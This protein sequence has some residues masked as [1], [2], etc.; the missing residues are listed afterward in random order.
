MGDS[1]QAAD[2]SEHST[3]DGAALTENGIDL[4]STPLTIEDYQAESHIET[5]AETD[6]LVVLRDT[7]GYELGE[8]A[9]DLG[10]SRGDLSGRMHELAREHYGREQIPGAGDPWSVTDPLVLAKS[11]DTQE[12]PACPYCDSRNTEHRHD[13]SDS[14]DTDGGI[15]EGTPVYY[16]IV[17]CSY[18][19]V[20]AASDD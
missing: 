13:Y 5:V 19:P 15:P 14:E 4:G 2:E 16:C 11:A 1:T 12:S 6:D 3:D 8:W 10:I 20:T 7:V 9:D 17:C 18:F